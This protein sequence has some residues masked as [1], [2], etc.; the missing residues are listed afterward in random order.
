[1][2]DVFKV[3]FYNQLSSTQVQALLLIRQGEIQPFVVLAASQTNGRGSRGRNWSSVNGNV[4]ATFVI[5]K[6][7]VREQINFLALI[8]SLAVKQTLQPLVNSSS[9][10]LKWPNDVLLEGKKVAGIL[11]EAEKIDEKSS[12]YWLI[13]IGINVN[14]YPAEAVFPATA[15]L[16]W[17]KSD[18]SLIIKDIVAK[19]G[20]NLHDYLELLD[21]KKYEVIRQ[22]WL[23][24]AFALNRHIEVKINE[25]KLVGEFI[26]L[27]NLGR[28]ILRQDNELKTIHTGVIFL[29]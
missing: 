25:S 24:S 19:L 4:Y 3:F 16:N 7:Y 27:D 5:Q 29:E 1:M 14:N 15:L 8:A 18:D 2:T 21:S 22:N 6:E 11:I 12:P 20:E 23:E 13:G 10:Q 9:V 17:K 26:G 28:L